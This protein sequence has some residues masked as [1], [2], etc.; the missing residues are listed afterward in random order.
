MSHHSVEFN[1]DQNHTSHHNA[2]KREAGQGSDRDAITGLHDNPE[3]SS[4]S[5][6][7]SGSNSGA[8]GGSLDQYRFSANNGKVTNLQEF[9]GGRWHSERIDGSESWSFD[10]TNLI[11]TEIGS[12]GTSISSFGDLDGDGI[13]TRNTISSSPLS[14]GLSANPSGLG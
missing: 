7:D 1:H 3:A 8:D 2:S 10:G 14:S 13:F 11:K 9:D 12:H 6:N 4:D 5:D